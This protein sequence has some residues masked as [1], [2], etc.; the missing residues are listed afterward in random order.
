M[1]TI[2]LSESTYPAAAP[3]HH[4][5]RLERI[6]H[7]V[8]G[9]VIEGPPLHVLGQPEVLLGYAAPHAHIGGAPADMWLVLRVDVVAGC[10]VHQVGVVG[11]GVGC[12]GLVGDRLVLDDPD[13]L[14]E[15]AGHRE[16][17]RVG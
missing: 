7:V 2:Y 16:T 1:G 13:V 12:E 15:N 17:I 6:P 8:A 10:G 11:R 4:V 5:D 3:A 9:C 14:H